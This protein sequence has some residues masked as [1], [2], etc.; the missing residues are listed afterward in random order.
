MHPQ[1]SFLWGCIF[2]QLFFVQREMQH[3][4]AFFCSVTRIAS[5]SILTRS[6]Y[7]YGRHTNSPLG[8]W[9]LCHYLV[10]TKN[11]IF[12]LALTS[13]ISLFSPWPNWEVVGCSYKY[14]RFIWVYGEF[15]H[16]IPINVR[17]MECLHVD[18][19]WLFDWLNEWMIDW[20]YK[21]IRRFVSVVP[22][23][24]TWSKYSAFS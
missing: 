3:R 7:F 15:S 8:F 17:T 21:C 22:C 16:D 24:N 20:L 2:G 10:C 19:E 4:S 13:H 12:F 14:L 5:R 18:V 23:L 1:P 9:F 11:L 6:F